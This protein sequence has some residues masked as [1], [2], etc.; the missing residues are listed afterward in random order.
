MNLKNALWMSALVYVLSFIITWITVLAG[1]AGIVVGV[2]AILSTVIILVIF[3]LLYFKAVKPDVREGFLFGIAAA[4]VGII[5][6]TAITVATNPAEPLA[7]LA[8]PLLWSAILMII[9][10]SII[11]GFL[12]GRK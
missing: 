10:I 7:N 5:I 1:G 11:V 9:G 2:I 12:K 3:E 6:D 4:V 8:N